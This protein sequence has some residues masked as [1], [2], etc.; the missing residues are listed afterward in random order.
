[1]KH[2]Y[3]DN[4]ATTAPDPAVL[5]T[6]SE[7]QA[8]Y[9]GNPSS[10][11]SLGQK[12]KVKLEQA[13]ATIAGYIGARPGEFV[14]TSSGT[15]SDNLAI[16]GAA[17]ANR[18]RGH[19]II[20]TR[21]EHPA[22]LQC[23][24][25]LS[26][27]GFEIKYLEIGKD[28]V[29]SHA[30]VND[31]IDDKTVLVSIMLANNETGHILDLAKISDAAAQ[32]GA[33]LHTDAVQALGKF[34]FDV[35]DLGVDLLSVSAHKIYGPKGIGG[36]YI[37][38]GVRVESR[39]LGGTQELNRRAGTENLAAAAGFASAIGKLA[40]NKEEVSSI[41][42]K[43]DLFEKLLLEKF[44]DVQINGR[45]AARLCSHSNI[46]FPFISGEGMLMN[47][48]MNGISVSAGSACSSGSAKPSHVLTALG[49]DDKRVANSIRFSFGR[50]NTEEEIYL[51]V[52]TIHGIYE[53]AR[54]R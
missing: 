53:S 36:L 32:N 7:I 4:A 40:D 17:L 3:L 6:M 5:R 54:N 51:T 1:M 47:L 19:R 42:R 16:I 21:I 25:Y 14:F 41:K 39:L 35:L 48:D 33:L 29:I 9:Y 8:D 23:M 12:S 44:P 27:R 20:S 30:A 22:V 49:Y 31:L 11:H 52:N 38:Q 10:I 18:T 2:I 50:F 13:R 46:Y 37:R 45:D 34:E 28:G 26:S 15:E 43:R 24:D